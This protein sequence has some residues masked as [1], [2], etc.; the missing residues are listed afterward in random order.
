MSLEPC[1][2]L[3]NE[4]PGGTDSVALDKIPNAGRIF[5]SRL[6]VGNFHRFGHALM[7]PQDM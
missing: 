4:L 6:L 1:G 2:R 3:G 5:L 7:I